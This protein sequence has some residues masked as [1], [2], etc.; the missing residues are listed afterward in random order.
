MKTIKSTLLFA[1]ALVIFSCTDDKKEDVATPEEAKASMDKVADEMEADLVQMVNTQGVDAL[2]QLLDL[3]SESDPF[4]GRINTDKNSKKIIAQRIKKLNTI[5]IPASAGI[6]EEDDRFIFENEVGVYDYNFDQQKFIQTEQG[7]DKVQLNF[8]TAEST[9]NN[10]TLNLTAYADVAVEDSYAGWVSYEPATINA[11]LSVDGETLV[12]LDFN[13]AYNE[14]GMPSSAEISLTL[15]PFEFSVSFSDD[16]ATS[17][18]VAYSMRNSGDKIMGATIDV[19]FASPDKEIVQIINGELY[20]RDISLKGK[21]DISKIDG[22]SESFD[23]NDFVDLAIYDGGTK[24]G[25][26]VFEETDWETVAY[27]KYSDG[28]KELLEELLAPVI[29]ELEDFILELEGE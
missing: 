29:S 4:S 19:S 20:Y 10:A 28:S 24:I 21:L 12:I 7:G 11:D 6:R 27:V 13:A 3:V 26:I 25:D 18:S 16:A 5:F 23:I 2:T 8:P 14:D 1:I 15:T 9:T 22:E 17:S